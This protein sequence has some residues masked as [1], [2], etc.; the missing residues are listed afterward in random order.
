VGIDGL[1]DELIELMV[2]EE[3]VPT[4]QMKVLSIMGFG[5]LGKT[6][7]ANQIYGKLMCNFDCGAFVSVSQKPNIRNIFRRMLSEVG[8]EAPEGTNM[9]IWAEDELISALRKFLMDKRYSCLE[10]TVTQVIYNVC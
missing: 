1:R 4:Q 5:G 7:L 6:T 10:M 3:D 9:D 8:Y 2:D